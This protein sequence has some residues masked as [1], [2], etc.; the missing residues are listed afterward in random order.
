MSKKQYITPLAVVDAILTERLLESG[1][2][3]I[4]IDKEDDPVTDPNEVYS[5]RRKDVWD[6]E[7]EEY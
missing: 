4:P 1:S 5:R 6:E 2:E 7:E 3:T